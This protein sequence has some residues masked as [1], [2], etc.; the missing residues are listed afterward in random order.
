MMKF[1]WAGLND[2][3]QR[4]RLEDRA[5]KEREEEIA[6]ARENTLLE[7]GLTRNRDRAKFRSSEPYREAAEAV[8]KLEKRLEDITF[9]DDTQKNFF[10]KLKTDPFAVKEVFDFIEEQETEYNNSV[11]LLDL[12]L[13][14]DIVTSNAPVDQQIDIIGQITSQSYVGEEGKQNFIDMASKLN[15]IVTTPGRNVFIDIKPGTRLDP[16]KVSA[17][18]EAMV[19]IVIDSIVNP[20]L[21][22]QINNPDDTKL[23][24]IL[25]DV[26]SK[27]PSI[28][29]KGLIQLF[30]YTPSGRNS[31]FGSPAELEALIKANPALKGFQETSIG[32]TILQG[33]V[34][35]T[36]IQESIDELRA[37]PSP[38]KKRIF[39]LTYGPGKADSYL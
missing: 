27:E 24:G 13:M 14:I 12:P 39:D 2:A 36:P 11:K 34:Y 3:Y 25:D 26:F 32:K 22:Y 6:L 9:V 37:D 15:N 38:E 29:Q 19:K 23:N 33:Y 31:S 30:N 21:M 16:V 5:D 1:S 18:E 4:K 10:D 17:K 35:P 7:L 28:K 20:A 8:I